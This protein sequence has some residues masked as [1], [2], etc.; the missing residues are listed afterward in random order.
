MESVII[1]EAGVS[2]SLTDLCY[3]DVWWTRGPHPRL[4]GVA[5]LGHSLVKPVDPKFFE[6][7]DTPPI[8]VES[9][10]HSELPLGLS[11]F[12]EGGMPTSMYSH[13]IPASAL[14]R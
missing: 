10:L 14:P 12:G 8:E 6:K 2:R 1:K 11:R 9:T 7:V 4:Q 5:A 13:M 3:P